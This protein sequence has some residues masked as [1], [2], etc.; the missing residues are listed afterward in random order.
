[1]EQ[2]KE[3]R[4]PESSRDIPQRRKKWRESQER[5]RQKTMNELRSIDETPPATP[6]AGPLGMPWGMDQQSATN[7]SDSRK[8]SGRKKVRRDR[9]AAYREIQR[10]KVA[11]GHK[12]IKQK[13]TKKKTQRA[14]TSVSSS[15]KDTLRS[16]KRAMLSKSIV[17]PVV[18]KYLFFHNV[19]CHSIRERYHTTKCDK[20][21]QLLA[22]M[23]ASNLLRKYRL[24]RTC[25]KST[26]ISERRLSSSS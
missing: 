10:L 7:S 15:I 16:K 6:V 13:K 21:R 23:V 25:R 18:K 24:M 1:M 19:L 8:L 12:N 20:A 3:S 2:R 14:K 22:S 5:S 26:S 17:N 11:G 9:S 4:K